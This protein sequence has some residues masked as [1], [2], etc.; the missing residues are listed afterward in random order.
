MVLVWAFEI[1][2]PTKQCLGVEFDIVTA[3]VFFPTG[4]SQFNLYLDICVK[5]YSCK[6]GFKYLHAWDNSVQKKSVMQRV[7]IEW[8]PSVSRYHKQINDG[9]I[10]TWS[11]LNDYMIMLLK[12]L[13][14][15][16]E[17]CAKYN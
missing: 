4:D 8:T 7:A 2:L 11:F 14:P 6:C 5:N 12:Y 13:E 16:F 1:A 9:C 10:I 3:G 15:E 17:I